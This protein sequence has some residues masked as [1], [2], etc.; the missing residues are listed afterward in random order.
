MLLFVYV[1]VVVGISSVALV[2]YLQL[3]Q[4]FGTFRVILMIAFAL[5]H[6]MILRHMIPTAIITIVFFH[7]IV[8]VF[9]VGEVSRVGRDRCSHA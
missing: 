6:Y 3:C 5:S 1:L 7:I 2:L 4:V 8:L 9:S